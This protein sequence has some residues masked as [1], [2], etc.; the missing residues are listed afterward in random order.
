MKRLMFAI[1][2]VIAATVIFGANKVERPKLVVGLVVD[3]M[4]WDYLYYYYEDFVEGGLKRLVDEG[5]SCENTMINYIPTIT[6]IGHTSV[7]TGSVPALHGITG[8]N[9]MEKG[10]DVYCC[11]DKT[12]EGVGTD[13]K[14]GRMSPRNNKATTIGDELRLATD[15][16]SRVFG[17]ALKDRAAIFPAGHSANAAY[18]Y[19]NTVG[20]FVTSTYYMDKLPAWV[21][22]FNTENATKKGEDQ[23]LKPEGV[24]ITFKMAEAIL[25]NERLGIGNYTDMLTISISSTDAIGHEY[26]TRDEH[27]KAAYMQLDRDLAKFLRV[28]DSRYGKDG[29]L[30]FLTADHGGAHNPNYLKQHHIYANGWQAS[31]WVKDINAELSKKYGVNKLVKAHYG[32][33]FYLDHA[34][35]DSACLNIDEVKQSV[36]NQ[37]LQEDELLYAVDCAK[38]STATLPA[39]IRERII[40]G[41]NRHRSGDIVVIPRSQMF[42]W[43]FKDDYKGTT[44]GQWNPYDAHIPLVFFGW[45]VTHGSTSSPTYIVDIAA[46]VC[47]MLHIEMP[48]SC[49]GNAIIPVVNLSHNP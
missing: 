5:F 15:F 31:Q 37:L 4:R 23:K 6:A 46:T 36:I 19:D 42:S 16:K 49:I 12:V 21:E 11:S 8:N 14:A 20:H 24:S 45:H 27:T 30:L 40:N 39:A 1:L 7:F 2:M 34:K 17:V 47:A 10:K 48:N 28:L 29:Y 41:Y 44:H 22:Q 33:F 26:G 35:I 3:Q 43:Q 13:T 38:A 9:F 18:W 25:R 32:D